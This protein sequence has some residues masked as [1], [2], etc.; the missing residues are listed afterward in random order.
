MLIKVIYTPLVSCESVAE[1]VIGFMMNL[2]KKMRLADIAAN[3]KKF[4]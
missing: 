3:V 1:H 2:L 4:H